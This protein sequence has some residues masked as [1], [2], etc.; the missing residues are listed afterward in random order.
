MHKDAIK[1]IQKKIGTTPDGEFGPKS[2]AACEAYLKKMMPKPHPWP[3]SDD[4]S[5]KRFFGLAGREN[6]LVAIDVTGLGIQYEGKTITKM[7]CHTKVAVSLKK[8]L[9]EISASPF[10]YVL[11]EYGGVYNYRPMRGGS[12]YS[13]HAWGVAID[14]DPDNNGLNQ[15]WPE[16]ASMPFGVIEIFAKHGWLSAGAFWNRDAMHFEAT[17]A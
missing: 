5:M 13:K 17:K 1:D 6:N 10:A 9:E 14:L 11:K 2:Q 7:R 3:N 12:R 4:A 15:N 16:S 8:I